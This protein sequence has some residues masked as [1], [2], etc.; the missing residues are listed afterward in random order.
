MKWQ[1]VDSTTVVQASLRLLNQ[2]H[3]IQRPL[4]SALE[5]S[6]HPSEVVLDIQLTKWNGRQRRLLNIQNQ[7]D[8]VVRTLS[9]LSGTAKTAQ[10]AHNRGSGLVRKTSPRPKLRLNSSREAPTAADP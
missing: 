3:Y 1:S 2:Y 4:L 8:S 10:R 7:G 9:M 5:M 6:V